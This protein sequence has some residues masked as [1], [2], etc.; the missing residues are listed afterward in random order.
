MWPWTLITEN[1]EHRILQYC[2]PWS[3]CT[4]KPNVKNFK[5]GLIIACKWVFDIRFWRIV[6]LGVHW[7]QKLRFFSTLSIFSDK[8]LWPFL[9]AR[10]KQRQLLQWLWACS[11]AWRSSCRCK[12]LRPWWGTGHWRRAPEPFWTIFF[13]QVEVFSSISHLC[14]RLAKRFGHLK[15]VS[16]RH[17]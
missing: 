3:K 17:W 16:S 6:Y 5:W 4:S 10:G 9:V 15:L 8:C 2:T 13:T 1:A 14:K 12:S 11:E 7:W